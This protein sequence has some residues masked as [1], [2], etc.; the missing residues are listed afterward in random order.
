M[1]KSDLVDRLARE[2]PGI[3]RPL[4]RELID[5]FIEA[6]KEG[7]A[8]RDTVELRDFGVLRIRERAPR[9]GRNPKT[10]ESVRVP[11][12]KVVYFKLSRIIKIKMKEK[13]ICE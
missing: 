1:T 4:A 2:F 10:G 11:A 12:K 9:K 3:T 5:H 13:P 6:M 7:L 8:A